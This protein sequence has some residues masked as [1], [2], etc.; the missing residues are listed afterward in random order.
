MHID[1]TI[2][3]STGNMRVCHD[4]DSTGRYRL[5]ISKDPYF[6]KGSCFT[7]TK[8]QTVELIE[9]FKV[10]TPKANPKTIETKI[11]CDLCKRK[12]KNIC[13][14]EKMNC[15]DSYDC[16]RSVELIIVK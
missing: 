14:T 13:K 7:P 10:F 2:K 9:L 3:N 1:T 16:F 5:S 6:V 15:E 8:E 11:I 12:G 4:G